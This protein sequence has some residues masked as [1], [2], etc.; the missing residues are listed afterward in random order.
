[1]SD[2][3]Y[4]TPS[5]GDLANYSAAR[6]ALAEAHRV[7]EVKSVRDKAAALQV[8]A[9]Q[10]KDRQLVVLPPISGCAQKFGR[11]SSSKTWNRGERQK[12]GE[13]W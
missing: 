12:A 10:A 11:A 2:P 5:L 9:Q 1:M 6:H 3:R 8:Y 4:E 7:D 13:R